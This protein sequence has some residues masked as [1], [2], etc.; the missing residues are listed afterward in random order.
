MGRDN[1]GNPPR[2]FQ[3]RRRYPGSAGT[4]NEERPRRPDAGCQT[5]LA[6][7]RLGVIQKWRRTQENT[8][9]GQRAETP[10][11]NHACAGGGGGVTREKSEGDKTARARDKS[12][13][14]KIER[15]KNR[16]QRGGDKG[17]YWKSAPKSNN[18]VCRCRG[19]SI[20]LQWGGS[21]DRGRR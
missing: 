11:K 3:L 7:T 13:Q 2:E 20:Q 1:H 17:V 21:C 8:G 10:K 9:M 6:K 19:H 12:H 16:T 4:R 5:R 18:G 14:I 15:E